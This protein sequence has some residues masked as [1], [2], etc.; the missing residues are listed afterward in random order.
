MSG[1]STMLPCQ[2]SSGCRMT[3]GLAVKAMPSPV[4]GADQ[5]FV[6]VEDPPMFWSDFQIIQ[7]VPLSSVN[8]RGSIEPPWLTWQ[9]YGLTMGVNGPV[10]DAPVA[11]PMH[12]IAG[13]VDFTR[14]VKYNTN[15][16]PKRWRSG[17]QV[18]P[19][20][21]HGGNVGMTSVIAPHRPAAVPDATG[22]FIVTPAPPSLRMRS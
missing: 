1:D 5:I 9:I 2:G 11:A 14:A 17:A 8:T 13:E 20:A 7:L 3:V 12:S 22:A 21:A 4:S 15:V 6:G 18:K 10:G 16:D 19:G